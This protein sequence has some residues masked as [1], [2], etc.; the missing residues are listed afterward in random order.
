MS[1]TR[2]TLADLPGV[3]ACE[4]AFTHAR[5]SE[6]SWTDE[7]TGAGRLTLVEKDAD[8]AVWG[9]ATFSVGPDVADLNRV[10]VAPDRRRAGVARRL[11][12]EGMAWAGESAASQMMLEVD[13]ANEPAIALYRHLGFA[14]LARRR[15]Y[16]GPGRDA[17]VMALDLGSGT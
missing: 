5:W 4:G 2:A 1:V 6:Q 13:D 17:L 3:M 14:P 15:N 11:V 10:V 7:I 12:L 16:Y 8:G 9:V